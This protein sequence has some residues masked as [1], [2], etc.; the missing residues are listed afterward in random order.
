M[1][2][3][4]VVA[5]PVTPDEQVALFGQCINQAIAAACQELNKAGQEASGDAIAMALTTKL[6]EM[7]GRVPERRE[8]QAIRGRFEKALRYAVTRVVQARVMPAKARQ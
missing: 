6:G 7:I 2:E 3:N 8:R 4:V 1:N 5:S